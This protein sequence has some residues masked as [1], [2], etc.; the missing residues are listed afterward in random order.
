M[1]MLVDSSFFS[2]GFAALLIR[3]IP[4]L[5][6]FGDDINLPLFLLLKLPERV[7]IRAVPS[8]ALIVPHPVAC[9]R[10]VWKLILNISSPRRP[11]PE[12]RPEICRR[13]RR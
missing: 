7:A 10:R 5:W 11:Y 13:H 6:E 2:R 9:C 3:A 1:F 4:D 8:C 12:I